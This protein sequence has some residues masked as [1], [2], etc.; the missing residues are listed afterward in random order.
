M[1]FGRVP[2]FYFLVHFYTIRLVSV[3]L[4][5][6]RYGNISFMFGPLPSMGGPL[7]LSSGLRL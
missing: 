7:I 6:L 2:L 5:W 1:V 4:A 3:I